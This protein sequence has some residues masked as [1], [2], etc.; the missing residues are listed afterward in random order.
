MLVVGRL[1]RRL[2]EKVQHIHQQQFLVLLLMRQSQIQQRLG[3]GRQ[4][5][6]EERADVIVNVLPVSQNLAERRAGKKPPPRPRLTR[7]NRLVIRIEQVAERWLELAVPRRAGGK[8]ESLEEAG[9][10][11][12]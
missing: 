1:Q 9:R 11:P 12:K 6:P 10:V 4:A 5:G 3:F 7:T 8:Q 2:A